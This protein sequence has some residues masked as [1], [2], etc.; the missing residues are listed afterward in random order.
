[1][2]P[3]LGQLFSRRPVSGILHVDACGTS[4][5]SWRSI[6]YLCP[7]L[8]PR[9]NRRGLA[10]IDRIDAAPGPNTPKASALMISG[11]PQ[12][13]STCCLR[14]TNGV[15]AA[16]ARLASGWLTNLCREGVEPSGPR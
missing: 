8:R 10:I 5:V 13:F 14:F 15:A 12:G 9:P 16:H 1:M 6:P 7:V 2:L 3:G 4:Q 11:L